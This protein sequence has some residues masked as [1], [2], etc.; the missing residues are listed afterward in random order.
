MP[1]A[2]PAARREHYRIKYANDPEYR[3]RVRTYINGWKR[4]QYAT[5]AAWRAQ[6]LA[7]AR[8]RRID[9]REFVQAI[10]LERGCVDCGYNAHAEAL[11]FDYVDDNK[12]T[13]VSKLYLF[14]R[15][16]ILREIAKCEVVCANCHRVRTAARR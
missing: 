16:I 9:N 7:D 1:Y 8:V 4:T 3:G 14:S 6:H 15:A 2:D 12:R 11:D 13:D 5:D 10:K